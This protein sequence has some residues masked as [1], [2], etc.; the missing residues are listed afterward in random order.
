MGVRLG[1]IAIET[2]KFA[3][4]KAFSEVIGYQYES[5]GDAAYLRMDDNACRVI[6][7]KGKSEDYAFSG[8]EVDSESELQAMVEKL[9]VAGISVTEGTTE[10]A[11]LRSVEHYVTFVDPAGSKV[12]IVLGCKSSD[13]PYASEV[14]PNGFVTGD[15]GMGHIA[16]AVPDNKA[17]ERFYIDLLDA[18]LSDHISHDMAGGTLEISFTHFNTRHHTFAFAASNGI[19][20][21]VAKQALSKKMNHFMCQ[22]HDIREVLQCQERVKQAKIPFALTLGEHTNDRDISFYVVTPSGFHLEVGAGAIEIDDST[23]VPAHHQG[24]S[25]WGHEFQLNKGPIVDA[26]M[27]RII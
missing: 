9:R 18:K 5:A 4:W 24:I 14:L 23:W 19:N 3:E 1:Y 12:D 25:I 11:E 15:Q 7:V 20:P 13:T 22:Y 17:C 8:L 26:I 6:L 21:L 16:F 27:K 10:G 2:K